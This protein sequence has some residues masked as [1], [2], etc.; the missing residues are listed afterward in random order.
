[1]LGILSSD[2]FL[3]IGDNM[4]FF[5]LVFS[6]F[7]WFFVQAL[8]FRNPYKLTFIFG[9]KGAGKSCLMV[10]EMLRY[11][12]MGWN[13]YTDMADCRIEG[14][15][16]IK[17]M[18]LASFR[19]EPHSLICLDEVGIT[20]DNRSFKSFP[21]GLRD[22]FKYARKMECRVIINS[23][24]F[25]V[26]KKVRDCVDDMILQTSIA[27]VFSLSRPIGR[28]ITLTEPTSESE[29]RIADKLYFLPVWDW[30][31][32]YMPAYHKYFDTKAMPD[33]ELCPY[34][35]PATVIVP[36]SFISD[37]RHVFSVTWFYVFDKFLTNRGER[38]ESADK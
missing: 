4:F 12:K 32:Y 5:I 25:D 15:R 14:V 20:M 31:I 35:Q 7:V 24:A 11:K 22:F 33:R 13:L 28:S 16:I 2:N 26:D 23:Q 37:M 21:P 36:T 6:F 10:K 30:K 34:D 19:P 8:R 29:S 18:D 38:G 9:K 1:M 3:T 27:G 17:A